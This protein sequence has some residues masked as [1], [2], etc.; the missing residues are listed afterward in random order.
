MKPSHTLGTLALGLLLLQPA[1]A[2]QP[3]PAPEPKA[4]VLNSSMDAQ[5]FYEVLLGEL[6][7]GAGDPGSSYALLLNAARRSH[8]ARLYERSV[9][10]A[11]KARAGD[12]ALSA[13][14]A[15]SQDLGVSPETQHHLLQILIGLNRFD[16]T[17]APLQT[18]LARLSGEQRL[19]LIA[20]LPR[21]Y[22]RTRD[23]KA[24]RE[25]VEQALQ[26]YTQQ[27]E[28]AAV[29]WGSVGRMRLLNGDL[30]DALQAARLGLLANPGAHS[31]ALLALELMD[32]RH[33]GAEA[34][35]QSHLKAQPDSTLRM[36]Y[37]RVLLD[38]RRID[39]ALGELELLTRD[40]SDLPEAWLLKGSLLAQLGQPG[41]ASQ[42]LH[43]YLRA[44]QDADG[45]DI[46]RG[47]NQAFVL[48]AELALQAQ[49]TSTAQ[50]WLDRIENADMDFALQ[51]R[52]ASLLG[53][54]G[55]LDRGLSL[56]REL[57][58]K[59]PAQWR[60]K[61]MLE[62][63]LL[64]DNG[65]F[66]NAFRILDMAAQQGEPDPELLY[67]Q[68]MLAEKLGRFAIMEQLLRR[69]MALQPDHHHAYN[70]LG[71]TLADRNERL[72]EA[73]L[74]ILKALEL[75]PGDPMVTDSLGW[76]E[77]RLGQFERALELLTQAYRGHP[78]A[79]IAAHLGEVLWAMGQQEQARDIWRQG[80]KQSA[81]NESLKATLARLRVNL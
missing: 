21:A 33:P 51:G 53:R 28:T 62:A 35:L 45:A 71:Y 41:A 42:S 12:A 32:L 57:P 75:A 20:A 34:V 73:R 44:T 2:Q 5:L 18:E 67:E 19:A 14:K 63:Q 8:D 56:I 22:A 36:G 27:A 59:S 64:R 13:V 48:M 40:R 23:K 29:A 65:H 66:D 68:A 61:R 15:W 52:R 39:D 7:A 43:R 60:A 17:L 1:W 76:V 4:T 38:L 37:V 46:Q 25:L 3:P 11:I 50:Q 69:V 47:R 49:E 10:I 79:E 6:S 24:A 74:L 54:L 26:P 16:E 80:L 30:G 78:D 58:E 77:F 55:Q 31:P 81:Q 9:D 72:P 70:A